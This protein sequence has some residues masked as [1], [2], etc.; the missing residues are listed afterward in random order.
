MSGYQNQLK[1][2]DWD[3]KVERL[4]QIWRGQENYDGGTGTE[5]ARRYYFDLLFEECVRRA[6]NRTFADRPRKPVDLLIS[7]MGY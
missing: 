2:E 7:W 4:R 1:P 5:N 3:Q 6:E